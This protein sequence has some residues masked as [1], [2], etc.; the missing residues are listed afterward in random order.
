MHEQQ[1]LSGLH[2]SR[3]KYLNQAGSI[4]ANLRFLTSAV[5]AGI[6]QSTIQANLKKA[7]A[8]ASEARRNA[9]GFALE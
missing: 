4:S 8:A 5:C 2:Y 9:A 7:H 3:A 6:L 1:V